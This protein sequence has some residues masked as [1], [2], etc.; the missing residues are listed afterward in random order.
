[1]VRVTESTR[2]RSAKLGVWPGIDGALPDDGCVRL[3]G[4]EIATNGV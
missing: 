3:D 2:L 4:L 1:M